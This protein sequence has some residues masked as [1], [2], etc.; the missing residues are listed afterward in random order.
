MNKLL[1]NLKE[2]LKISL[3]GGWRYSA[4]PHATDPEIR[5]E[6]TKTCFYNGA[7]EFYKLPKDIGE[8]DSSMLFKRKLKEYLSFL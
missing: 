4:F 7:I 5:L 1:T 2:N 3:S 8:I 6:F